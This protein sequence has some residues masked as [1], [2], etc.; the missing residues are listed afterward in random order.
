MGNIRDLIHRIYRHRLAI[1]LVAALVIG[2]FISSL[3]GLNSPPVGQTVPITPSASPTPFVPQSYSQTFSQQQQV[4]ISDQR[5][6]FSVDTDHQLVQYLGDTPMP[7]SQ[8]GLNVVDY[9]VK[10]GTVVYQ[11]GTPGST[12]NAY[13]FL[14]LGN[15]YQFQLN[16]N[17]Y[18]PIVGY[19]IDPLGDTLAFLGNYSPEKGTS[20]LYFYDFTSN[21]AT[22]AAQ[23]TQADS[24]SWLDKSHL[25]ITYRTNSAT[26][27]NFFASIYSTSENDF[28]VADIPCLKQ[29]IIFDQKRHLLYFIDTKNSKLVSL[30]LNRY[31]FNEILSVSFLPNDVILDPASGHL[32]FLIG[33]NNQLSVQSVDPVKKT[34]VK[35][36]TLQLGP[37]EVY[38]DH[39]VSENS[40]F[41]KTYDR[42]TQEYS[43]RYLPL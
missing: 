27:P 22:Q 42:Q 15:K 7:I 13:Y 5:F 1:G 26:L 2:Y 39:F 41:I 32:T 28:P 10:G 38:V 40:N 3:S 34:T 4:K 21:L 12:D 33:Q 8:P 14:N 9:A 23:D 18:R 6:V 11:A 20:S 29:S 17:Q 37:N 24:V 19:D 30:D 43:V 36:S 25:L 16:I 31:F 35:Q